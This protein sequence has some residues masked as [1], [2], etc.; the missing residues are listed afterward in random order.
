MELASVILIAFALAMDAFAVALSTG[1]YLVKVDARQTFRLSFHFGLFQF[2]MPIIGGFAG[3]QVT[4][5]F[6]AIDHWIAFLLLG[7]IGFRM[8][9]SSMQH[10]GNGVK[11]DVTRGSALIALS[12]ATS[13]DALAV[14]L[15]FSM[16]NS[17]IVYPSVVIG[18]VASGMTIAGLRLGER[19]SLLLG[20]K[21]EFV[22]GVLLIVIGIKLVIDHVL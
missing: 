15:T 20:K 11:S 12:L 13:M 3:T 5:L 17:S 22:G 7:Y 6:T 1:A 18:I 14:G 10:H 9:R 21:M 4:H 8:I 19:F 16:I 2:L